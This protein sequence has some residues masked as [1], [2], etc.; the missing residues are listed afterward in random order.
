MGIRCF[1]AVPLEQS[2]K[3][4]I[5]A[6]VADLRKSDADVK[7]VRVENLHIT[8]RF[9]GDTEEGFLPV[10]EDGLSTVAS[11]HGSLMVGLQGIGLFPKKG[12]PRIVWIDISNCGEL[13]GLQHDI[14]AALFTMGIEKED[15]PFS[16]H[17]TIGRVRSPKNAKALFGAL[18]SFGDKDFGTLRIRSFSLMKSELRP[19]GPEYTTLKEFDLKKEER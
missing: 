1:I 9:L 16:P 4:G 18:Q 5:A 17:L 7:W 12:A 6:S 10:L 3:E 2:L 8:L 13:A 15:R 14:E 19:A 11:R